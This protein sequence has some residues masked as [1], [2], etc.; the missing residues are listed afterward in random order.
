MY[1]K[2]NQSVKT[3]AD[4]QNLVTSVILR[5][6]GE[7]S[8]EDVVRDANLRLLDSP[9]YGT[10]ELTDRCDDTLNTLFLFNGIQLV[11]KGKYS[12]SLSWPAIS[13]R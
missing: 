9:Y 12:L 6:T 7:F 1:V 2:Q 3:R 5:Q 11:G 8:L 10:K 13:K 4:L